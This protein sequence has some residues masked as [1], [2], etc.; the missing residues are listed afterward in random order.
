MD[1][2]KKILLLVT[3]ASVGVLALCFVFYQKQAEHLEKTVLQVKEELGVLSEG[4]IDNQ[5]PIRVS[6]PEQIDLE[7][8]EELLPDKWIQA[9]DFFGD[10]LPEQI[11]L[12]EPFDSRETGSFEAVCEITEQN[13]NKTEYLLKVVVTDTTKPEFRGTDTPVLIAPGEK[14]TDRLLLL[15]VSL[16]DLEEELPKENIT[17]EAKETIEGKIRAVYQGRDAVGNET[18][19][20]REVITDS[21]PP[22]IEVKKEALERIALGQTVDAEYARSRIEIRDDLGEAELVDVKILPL[23]WGYEIKYEAA[24]QVGNIGELTEKIFYTDCHIAAT[25]SVDE[26]DPLKGLII[27]D[28]YGQPIPAE[29]ENLTV[30]TEKA[31]KSSKNGKKTNNLTYTVTYQ[32]PLGERTVSCVGKI[33]PYKTLTR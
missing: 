18:V 29:D 19:I 9:A 32:C 7:R 23:D 3:A 22:Q 13:G 6:I 4:Q 28:D 20:E 24:D 15:G 10:S 21:T 8:G 12:Q 17:L 26:K 11:R 5:N 2:W 30:E 14:L 31:E 27:T 16:W 1:K 25:D 33:S